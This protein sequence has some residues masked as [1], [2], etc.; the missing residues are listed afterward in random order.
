[1]NFTRRQFLTYAGATSAAAL[2]ADGLFI[3]PGMVEF[4]HHE[5]GAESGATPTRVRFAQISDLH[6]SGVG[7]MH[8]EIAGYL[9]AQRP[10]FLMITGDSIDGNH[11]MR[12]LD[13]FL[14]LFDDALPKYAILGNWEHWGHVS[15]GTLGQ[16][17][18]TR[19]CK[20]LVNAT[21]ERIVGGKRLL[22]TGLDDYVAGMPSEERALR[23]ILPAPHHLIMAHCPVHRDYLAN[24]DMYA[25]RDTS[26]VTPPI[27]FASFHAGYV[28]SGH[29][30]GGQVSIA[31]VRPFMPKGSGEYVQGWYRDRSPHLYVSRGIGTSILPVRIGARPEV[32][33]FDMWV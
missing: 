4:T 20:L 28:F 33:I 16:L 32:A 19:G 13:D 24:Y 3:E 8:R 22:I 23:D 21:A 2:A 27:D 29:T 10:D 1:M 25:R 18:E 12:D 14:A 26:R 6:L 5:L 7:A 30:H 9:R 31:G 17:Y 15:I 11:H